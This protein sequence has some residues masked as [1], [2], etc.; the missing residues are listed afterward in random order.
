MQDLSGSVAV[1]NPGT[2][3]VGEGRVEGR[4]EGSGELTD[5]KA[6]V[7]S[8]HVLVPEAEA[9]KLRLLSRKTRVAQSEYLREA[10]DDLLVK[11]DKLAGKDGNA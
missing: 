3:G 10:V 7:V 11:Y 9:E 1:E 2:S 8:T 5:R 4:G 6:D